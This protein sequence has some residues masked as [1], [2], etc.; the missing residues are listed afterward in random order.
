[1]NSGAYWWNLAAVFL[2][3]VWLLQSFRPGRRGLI[4]SVLGAALLSAI[5]FFGHELRYWLGGLT[6]N[7]SIPLFVLLLVGI[8]ERAGLPALFR[9]RDWL[10]AWFFGAGA[11]LFLYPSSLGLGL[12]NFDS[13]SLGW[14]WLDWRASLLLFG[15]VALCA[16]ILLRRGNRFGWVLVLVSAGFLLRFQ[17]SSNFWDYLLDPLYAVVALLLAARSLL[18]G[19]RSA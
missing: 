15:P 2:L 12:R 10:A 18:T 17:E 16:A 7:V 1:M 11:A 13:Y 14:P 6:P 4:V 8:L 5:P 3:L 19:R 9:S